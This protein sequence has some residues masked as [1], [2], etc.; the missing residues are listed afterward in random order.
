MGSASRS[1]KAGGGP[2]REQIIPLYLKKPMSPRSVTTA[3]ASQ[4]FRAAGWSVE[5]IRRA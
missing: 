5:S 4:N 3:R 2:N 1:M